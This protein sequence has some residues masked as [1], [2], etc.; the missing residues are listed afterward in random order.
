MGGSFFPW[1]SSSKKAKKKMAKV[2]AKVAEASSKSLPVVRTVQGIH[3]ITK[4][5][6]VVNN[7]NE[8]TGNLSVFLS[9]ASNVADSVDQFIPEMQVMGQSLC[10][11]ARLFTYFTVA[12]RRKT[13]TE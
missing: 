7:V 13:E 2:L 3:G 4:L 9:K 11:S 8:A 5:G 10:D 6:N 1:L 12:A